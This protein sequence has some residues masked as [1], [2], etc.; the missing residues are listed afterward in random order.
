MAAEAFF[1]LDPQDASAVVSD[2]LNIRR[3][4]DASPV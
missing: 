2:M 3:H 4:Q 1:E